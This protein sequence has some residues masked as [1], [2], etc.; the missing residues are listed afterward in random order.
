MEELIR[1]SVREAGGPSRVE[2]M[3]HAVWFTSRGFMHRPTVVTLPNMP[4]K[5]SA[6]QESRKTVRSVTQAARQQVMKN[7]PALIRSTVVPISR[8]PNPWRRQARGQ[9]V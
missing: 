2:P 3:N 8:V 7:I 6:S 5:L 1:G 4:Q 9:F